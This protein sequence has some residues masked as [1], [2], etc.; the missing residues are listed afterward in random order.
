MNKF[1]IAIVA[2]PAPVEEKPPKRKVLVSLSLLANNAIPYLFQRIL[3]R[4]TVSDSEEDDVVI[5]TAPEQDIE[6]R[7]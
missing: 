3:S 1:L 5:T 2:V 6:V 4:A 7:C